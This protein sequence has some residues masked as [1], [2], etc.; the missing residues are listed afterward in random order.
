MIVAEEVVKTD[1][2][3]MSETYPFVLKGVAPS[4]NDRRACAKCGNPDRHSRFVYTV[5]TNPSDAERIIGSMPHARLDEERPGLLYFGCC[6]ACQPALKKFLGEIYASEAVSEA[7][8]R[9]E[10]SQE[11]VPKEV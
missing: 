11:V 1:E 8:L 2:P 9:R 4:P 6:Y 3:S 10:F 5:E 7:Q